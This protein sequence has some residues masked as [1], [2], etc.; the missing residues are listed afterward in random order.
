MDFGLFISFSISNTDIQCVM[1][2]KG[3]QAGK[4]AMNFVLEC[5]DSICI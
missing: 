1:Y 5:M 4:C 3:W 2:Y